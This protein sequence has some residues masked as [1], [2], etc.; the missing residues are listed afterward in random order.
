MTYENMVSGIFIER[1]NRFIAHVQVCGEIVVAHVKNTG[2]CKELLIPGATVILRKENN[3][4]RKTPYSLISVYK[5]DM[6]INMDSQIPNYVVEEALK[7]DKIAGIQASLVKRE[8]TYMSSRFDIFFHNK[9]SGKDAFMEVKGVTLEADGIAKFPDAPTARGSKHINHLIHAAKEGYEA[10]IF[11]LVQINGLETFT[12]NRETDPVF[13][14]TLKEAE[15][16]GVKILCYN[17]TVTETSIVTCSPM[18][19]IL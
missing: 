18:E 19:I 9:L 3:E 7:L 16:C 1:P 12:P 8:K 10:Y 11:F 4:K 2:R 17:S 15:S 6:L 14:D 13:A 5:G